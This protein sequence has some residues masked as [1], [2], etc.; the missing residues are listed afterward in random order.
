MWQR[1]WLSACSPA[2]PL[3]CG[4]ELP[5][6]VDRKGGL[7]P[8]AQVPM[9][10]GVVLDVHVSTRLAGRVVGVNVLFCQPVCK[11]CESLAGQGLA[12]VENVGGGYRHTQVCAHTL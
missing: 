4:Q 5:D 10:D 3:C 6:E 7:L 8:R 11:M 12:N 9:E 2:S 1:D